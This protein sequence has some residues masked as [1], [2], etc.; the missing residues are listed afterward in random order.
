MRYKA[1]DFTEQFYADLDQG[2]TTQRQFSANT[3]HELCISLIVMQTSLEAPQNENNPG[4]CGA[5]RPAVPSGRHVF[6][7]D[8][9]LGTHLFCQRDT[10]EIHGGLP[11]QENEGQRGRG[12][13]VV[14]RAEPPA[15][16]F[17]R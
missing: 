4:D 1:S 14:H 2:F 17:P 11:G 9:A 8:E 12:S 5:D 7:D 13:T 10:K 15:H 6:R 3:A 16:H